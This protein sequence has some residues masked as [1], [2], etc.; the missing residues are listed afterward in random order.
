MAEAKHTVDSNEIQVRLQRREPG[1]DMA[2]EMPKYGEPRAEHGDEW[3][4]GCR[5]EN[6][7]QAGTDFGFVEGQAAERTRRTSSPRSA[8]ASEMAVDTLLRGC[9]GS[10][11]GSNSRVLVNTMARR[12]TWSTV[13]VNA[14]NRKPRT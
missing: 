11:D 9:G 10:N 7:E 1:R 6:G 5:L 8:D 4:G 14:L 13:G 3:V 12:T 2:F